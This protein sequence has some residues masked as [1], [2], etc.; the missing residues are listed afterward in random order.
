MNG[1]TPTA[2]PTEIRINLC[3]PV[4][5]MGFG[6]FSFLCG[7]PHKKLYAVSL[8]MRSHRPTTL[9]RRASSSKAASHND[10]PISTSAAA[11]GGGHA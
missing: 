11:A 7:A 5:R 3:M 2:R 9:C 1:A 6:P 4:T 10:G 8:S